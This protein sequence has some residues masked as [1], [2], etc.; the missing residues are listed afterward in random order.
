MPFTSR[1]IAIHSQKTH[2]ACT[3]LE[4]TCYFR[5]INHKHCVRW[6]KTDTWCY[7]DLQVL[8]LY[9]EKHKKIHALRNIGMFQ[10]I[11]AALGGEATPPKTL[12]GHEEKK[13]V[14]LPCSSAT[15]A[16]LSKSKNSPTE[17]W[18]RQYLNWSKKGTAYQYRLA[19]PRVLESKTLN[20]C[21]DDD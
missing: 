11:A 12:R 5:I 1:I 3:S 4:L 18:V 20:N 10:K 21:L 6:T 19:F 17:H 9:S 13:N 8:C 14:Y 15:F 16:S 7:S 2:S